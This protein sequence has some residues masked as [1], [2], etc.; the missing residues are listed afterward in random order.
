M[1]HRHGAAL[2]GS[3]AL[4]AA[5]AAPAF[6]QDANIEVVADGLDTPR[7][8]AIASDGSLWV[9]AAGSNGDTCI[10][11][12]GICYGPT[13]AIL[14]ITDGSVAKVIDGLSSA[15]TEQ[16]VGGVSDLALID[17]DDFYFIM[18]LGADPA[19]RVGMP[20][21]LQTAGWLMR[22]SSDGSTEPVADVA[23]FE[24]SDDPDAEFTGGMPDSN[25][26]SIA[27][28]DG[29]VA[30]ADAGGNDLLLVDDAGTVSLAAL[31]PPTMHEFPAELL[32][33]MGP[34]PEGEGGP[35]AEGEAPP[36]SEAPETGQAMASD[37]PAEGAVGQGDMVSIPIQS[38]PTSVVVGPDGAFYVGE[39]TGGPFPIGGASVLRVAPGEEPAV[40]ATGF[41]NIIDLGF[42]PDGTLY[43]AE[44]V[45][46]GLMGLFAG[47]APPIGA[48]LSVPPGGGDPTLV[49]TGEQVM[50]PGG[51]AVDAD[52][53]VYVTTGTVM[54]PGA[55]AVIKITP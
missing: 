24:A 2:A 22:G 25:P 54:G 35:P 29:G 36:A 8:I 19:D 48:I 55:G 37:A 5:L 45:H 39:L 31:F 43:V 6:A 12:V 20:D 44:I 52:G 3:L 1:R 7:G 38:V 13:G 33:Q 28:G 10:D 17:D 41:T 49:A 42:A 11:E 47:D 27:I 40:Y 14:R 21:E 15:G 50:A 53:S 26:Y 46:E 16:E 23:A 18:N 51:L 32:A 30:V 9:A 34:P 4:V